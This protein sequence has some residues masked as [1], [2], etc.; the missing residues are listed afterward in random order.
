[1][2]WLHLREK[3]VRFAVGLTAGASC[4]GIDAAHV[5][6]RGTGPDTAIKLIRHAHFPYETP[7]RNRLLMAR[8]D[9]KA[10]ALL[11]FELGEL[12]AQAA[13]QVGRAQVGQGFDPDFIAVKGFPAAHVPQRNAEGQFGALEIGEPALA[14]HRIGL[15]VV[16]DFCARDMAAQGQGAPIFSYADHALFARQDRTVAVLHLGALASL[17][18]LPPERARV[19]SFE[20][21]PCNMALDG[22]IHLITSGNRDMDTDGKAAARGV[23]IDEFLEYLLDRPF[24]NRVPPKSTSRDEFGPEVYLRDAL[25]GRKDRSL[26][27]LLATV[28]A[29]V[30]FSIIRA[31]TRFVK[32]HFEIMRLILTGGGAQNLTLVE[33]LKKGIPDVVLRRSDEYGLPCTAVDPVRV[34]VLGNETLCG[35]PNNIPSATGAKSAVLLG[36][37]TPP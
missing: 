6:I 1:M 35:T 16:S 23:V 21:G 4:A 36:R 27:D 12:L 22:A 29:A 18:V 24:F 33:H 15:P 25:S 32:P 2:K 31:Y 8:K 17:T 20:T 7:T 37:I 13:E 19:I 34:A 10:L 30:A 9:A 11:H 28:T 5:R 3:E 26:E 14:A